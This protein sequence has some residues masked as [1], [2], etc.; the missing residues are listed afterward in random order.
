MINNNF[1][2]QVDEAC[3]MKGKKVW[4]FCSHSN[5]ILKFTIGGFEIK[6]PSF[7]GGFDYIVNYICYVPKARHSKNMRDY[8]FNINEIFDNSE[9]CANSLIKE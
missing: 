6:T 5:K 8:Y 2:K 9:E 3:K 1:Q 4:A 7:Y